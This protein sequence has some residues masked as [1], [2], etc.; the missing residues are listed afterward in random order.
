[1]CPVLEK[2]KAAMSGS[3]PSWKSEALVG[4]GNADLPAP[5]V[6]SRMRW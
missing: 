6:I 3:Q 4:S 5:F 2:V 1:M